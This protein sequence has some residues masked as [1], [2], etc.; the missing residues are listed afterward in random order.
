MS[1]LIFT[2]TI[3][4][5]IYIGCHYIHF[6][7]IKLWVRLNIVKVV[8]PYIQSQFIM[9][10]NGKNKPVSNAYQIHVPPQSKGQ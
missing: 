9:I 10:Q 3:N 6:T 1:R 4:T 8:A 7:L 2:H 5:C